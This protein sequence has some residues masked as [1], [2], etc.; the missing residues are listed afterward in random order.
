VVKSLVSGGRG[1]IVVGRV[2]CASCSVGGD[3]GGRHGSK[4]LEKSK[5]NVDVFLIRLKR[6]LAGDA[7]LEADILAIFGN[8]RM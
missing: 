1:E 2:K 7:P 8:Q 5:F 6:S 4:W 3:Y